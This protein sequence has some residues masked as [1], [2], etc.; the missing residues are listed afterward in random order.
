M[1][2]GMSVDIESILRKSASES[3]CVC[4]KKMKNKNKLV[5]V[6]QSIHSVISM[7]GMNE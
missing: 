3:V 5:F 7:S 1:K 6:A 4:G 2:Y